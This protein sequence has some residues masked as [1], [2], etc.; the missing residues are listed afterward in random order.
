VGRQAHH[1]AWSRE[2]DPDQRNDDLSSGTVI[3]VA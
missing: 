3:C 1:A 2:N